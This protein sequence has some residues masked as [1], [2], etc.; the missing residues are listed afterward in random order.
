MQ[1]LQVQ[2]NVRRLTFLIRAVNKQMM[3]SIHETLSLRILC[4]V[5][6]I[7]L[8]SENSDKEI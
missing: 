3:D 4:V 8:E 5:Q 2:L 1:F 7:Y 6:E